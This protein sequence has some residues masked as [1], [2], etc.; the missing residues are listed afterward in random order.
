[1]TLNVLVVRQEREKAVQVIVKECLPFLWLPVS[2][3]KQ[4]LRA[5]DRD[6]EVEIPDW[7]WKAKK[8][9]LLDKR[10]EEE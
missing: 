5:G 9:E 7:L 4:D 3:L 10:N 8:Q 6:I 1:M 2:Q